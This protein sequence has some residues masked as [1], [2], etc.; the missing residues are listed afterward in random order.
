MRAFLFF[1]HEKGLFF[2]Y[3]PFK[4]NQQE[5]EIGYVDFVGAIDLPFGR[6][7]FCESSI[8]RPSKVIQRIKNQPCRSI[9]MKNMRGVFLLDRK[10]VSLSLLQI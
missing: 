6:F 5:V 4:L 8:D 9:R 2:S 1:V 7:N 3:L 10:E